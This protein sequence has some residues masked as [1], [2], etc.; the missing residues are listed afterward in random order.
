MFNPRQKQIVA[1]PVAGNRQLYGAVGA[2]TIVHLCA[3]AAL[4][5]WWTAGPE[6]GK[7]VS[8]NTRLA[9]ES[10]QPEFV[11]IKTL[12]SNDAIPE[13]PDAKLP[14]VGGFSRIVSPHHSPAF[15]EAEADADVAAEASTLSDADLTAAVQPLAARGAPDGSGDAAGAGDGAGSGGGRSFFDQ[16]AEGRRFVFV[17]DCSRS[18]HHP[19]D[20][21]FKTRFKRLKAELVKSVGGMNESQEF[22]IF[23]FNDNSIPMPASGMEPATLEKRRHYLEWVAKVRATGDTDPRPALTHAMQLKPD[24]IYFLT[25]GAFLP[26]IRRDLLKLRQANVAIHTFALGNAASESMLRTFAE[27]NG[28]KYT[29][30]P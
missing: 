11:E 13:R 9:T 21:E 8:L 22:F 20:S 6:P 10:T 16:H 17:V 19:H 23:F 24:V 2:S 29:F 5:C 25:D 1:N 3:I 30:V 4:G 27:Q 18:M 7:N 28:G 15:R 26:Y 14:T 12:S